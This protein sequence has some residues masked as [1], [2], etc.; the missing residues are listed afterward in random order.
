MAR[1]PAGTAAGSGCG[2]WCRA[3]AGLSLRR[4]QASPGGSHHECSRRRSG[5]GRRQLSDVSRRRRVHAGCACSWGSGQ[6]SG[7]SHGRQGA[8]GVRCL[9]PGDGVVWVEMAMG[10]ADKV[11][12]P[13]DAGMRRL[14][15]ERR[16]LADGV[17]ERGCGAGRAVMARGSQRVLRRMR[18]RGA[19]SRATCE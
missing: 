19:E 9:R 14:A 2:A 15:A 6:S 12:H 13:T 11:E 8:R 4:E 17:P 18:L 16:R 1:P 7:S 3:C 5:C 10:A